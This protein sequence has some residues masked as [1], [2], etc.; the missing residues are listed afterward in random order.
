MY[1]YEHVYTYILA[2]TS[3]YLKCQEKQRIALAIKRAVMDFQTGPE[4]VR[5]IELLNSTRKAPAFACIHG[6]GK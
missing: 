3:A 5:W 2:S 6:E 1:I 4:I